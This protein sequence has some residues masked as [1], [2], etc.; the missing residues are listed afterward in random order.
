MTIDKLKPGMTVYSVRTH[1]MGNTSISSVGAYPV[2]IVSI[3]CEKQKVRARLNYNPPAD[4][5]RKQWSKWRLKKPELVQDSLGA[6][7]IKKKNA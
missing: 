6:C 1:K 4:Y 7:S 5:S 2:Q 3:D